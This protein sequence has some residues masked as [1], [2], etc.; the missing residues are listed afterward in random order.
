MILLAVLGSVFG[1]SYA[2]SAHPNWNPYTAY[3][4]NTND[5]NVN[6]RFSEVFP[7]NA[8]RDRVREGADGWGDVGSSVLDFD[9]DWFSSDYAEFTY[10]LSC[11]ENPD[12]TLNRPYEKDAVHQYDI[13]GAGP[14]ITVSCY[15]PN[16]GIHDFQIT[17]D[18]SDGRY[19][20]Y[21][22]T[23]NPGT[24][25]L[26]RMSVAIHEFGHATGWDPHFDQGPTPAADCEGATGTRQTMCGGKP[27]YWNQG[28]TW[29]RTLEEHDK[30]E[31][32]DAY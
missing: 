20:W 4:S 7:S 21:N 28:M 25:Q 23:G 5:D 12:G 32:Q 14:A 26:D 30:H 1:L 3:W 22:T 27:E 19:N 10:P 31:L 8:A 11:P 2:A 15:T 24:D 13:D 16:G 17:F 18:A 6:W 9:Y 29:Q